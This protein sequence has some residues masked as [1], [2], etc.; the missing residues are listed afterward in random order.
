MNSRFV[1]VHGWG[2]DPG[3]WDGLIDC[4]PEIETHKVDLGFVGASN[5][6][7]Y[8]SS[9]SAIYITHSLGTMWA[10]QN[11]FPHIDALISMNGFGC[12]K[13]FSD[14]RVLKT[15]KM[16]LQRDPQAQM[17]EFWTN[18]DLPS[19]D[20]LNVPNLQEGLEWLDSW[21]LREELAALT[22]PVLSLAGDN[23]PILP[24]DAMKEAWAAFDLRVCEGGRHALPISH[25][26]WCAEHVQEFIREL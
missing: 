6:P 16:R 7:S 24:I 18:C 13:S 15:M 22:C 8:D 12:F 14:A 4:L 1:F 25:A 21:D 10:L 2:M 11:H 26:Q 23:D 9:G 17:K 3:F 19:N 20:H 5:M